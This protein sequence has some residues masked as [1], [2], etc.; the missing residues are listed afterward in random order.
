MATTLSPATLRHAGNIDTSPR[1]RATHAALMEAARRGLTTWEI[2]AITGSCAV[3]SDLTR[4]R[5][6]G[7]QYV[8]RREADSTNGCRVHRYW[9]AEF[10]P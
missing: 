9:L 4:L 1:L 7:F 8:R 3:H 6:N 5:A 10:A 2:A